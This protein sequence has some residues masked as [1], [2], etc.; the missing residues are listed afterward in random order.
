MLID[1]KYAPGTQKSPQQTELSAPAFTD[2]DH[3]QFTDGRL[4]TIPPY[5]SAVFTAAT[6]ITGTACE[7]L[8]GGLRSIWAQKLTGTYIGTYYFFATN[9]RL[10]VVKNNILF[11]ITPIQS[12]SATTL[13]NNPLTMTSGS[14]VVRVAH[15]AHGYVT[16]DR[17]KISGVGGAV[18]GIPQVELEAE[19]IIKK[20]DANAYDIQVTTT[21]ATS[22]GTGGGAG[23]GVKGQIAA[24]NLNQQA[25][26][27]GEFGGGI[28]GAGIFGSG[29]T[30]TG[31]AQS[32][33]RIW[34]FAT[35]GN[36]IA[37]CPG[38]YE[39]GDGQL[40]Y[41]WDGNTAIA[42]TKLTNSL[43]G[44]NWIA[45]VNNSIVAARGRTIS[46][47]GLGT[48][49]VWSGL[50]FTEKDLERV[51]KVVSIHPFTEKSAVMFTPNEAILLRYDGTAGSL[52][53]M[54]D[55]FTEDGILSPMSAALLDGVLYWRGQRG[56]YRY[57]GGPVTKVVNIQNE[58][59][60]L[61]NT[62]YGQA[63][64]SFAMSDPQN[65]QWWHYFPTGSDNEPNDYVIYNPNNETPSWT[66]GEMARTAAQRP[67][68]LDSKLYMGNG[69]SASVAGTAYLHFTSGAVTFDWFAE[70]AF[71]YYDDGS[72]RVMIDK[73]VPD[74]NQDG[75]IDL[76]FYGR[77]S[78]RGAE[79]T[80]GPYTIEDD[81]EHVSVKAAGHVVK[82]RFE[83]SS[84]ATMGAYKL[85]VKPL[86][87]LLGVR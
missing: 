80:F 10:M 77:E 3:V 51:W 38:D 43:T 83:G 40:I 36:N 70:Q 12:A 15:T 33:P 61:A 24:G 68:V 52:W 58:D 20:F 47:C 30:A 9:T 18:R 27:G 14:K 39:A 84:A 13:G 1:V 62:N 21:T 29:G 85:N 60:I 63:W 2:T 82:A 32:Y 66:L 19:F 56:V 25:L 42:P 5:N 41:F 75:D 65:G 55:L 37:M 81:T 76:T 28:F 44:N 46:I 6:T 35:F 86:G 74:G 67:G 54:S 57:D 17:I 49:T 73:V 64:K 50:T 87:S 72:Q 8:L 59:W 69:T 45:G 79:N 7:S 11:N 53:D 78:P 71:A 23:V 22:S 26:Q 34:S 48:E 31:D 16:G 4:T